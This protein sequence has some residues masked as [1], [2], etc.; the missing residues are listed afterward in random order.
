MN[1]DAF[2]SRETSTVKSNARRAKRMIELSNLVGLP[3]PFCYTDRNPEYD[4]VG[5][6]VAIEILLLSRRP[7]RHSSTHTQFDTLRT[8]RSTYSNFSKSAP[9]NNKRV[10]ALGDFNGNFNRL[11]NDKCASLFFKR[12]I[13]G[14]RARMGQIWKPNLAMSINLL[15]TVIE[16]I[17]TKILET[18]YEDEKHLW[19][20]FLFYTTFTYALSLRGPEGLLLDLGGL[21]QYWNFSSKYIVITLLGRIKGEK[22]DLLHRIPCSHTTT[23]GLNLCG[24][25]KRLL[26]AKQKA[27]FSKGPAISDIRGKILSTR[28]LDDMLSEVLKQVHAERPNLFPLNIDEPEKIPSSYQCFRTFRRT[29]TTRAVE[30]NVSTSDINVV[31]KWATKQAAQGKPIRSTMHEHYTQFDLLVEPFLRYTQQM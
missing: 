8:L 19:L 16:V 2:W 1:L 3:G 31:N 11:V 7:G 28:A 14:L 27:G 23:S 26:E 12:F 10:I 30:Q 22:F 13:E 9:Q 21:N 5:Y 25:L 24:L 20:V 18:E 15:V 6:E 17:E 4:H 29:S